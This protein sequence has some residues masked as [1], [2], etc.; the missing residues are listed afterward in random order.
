M[1]RRRRRPSRQ[2]VRVKKGN[3]FFFLLIGLAALVFFNRDKINEFLGEKKTSTENVTTEKKEKVE[4]NKEQ[5]GGETSTINT[6]PTKPSAPVNDAAKKKKEEKVEKP[7]GSSTNNTT[8]KKKPLV[9]F[10]SEFDKTIFAKY[11]NPFQINASG[12]DLEKVIPVAGSKAVKIQ[13]VDAKKGTYKVRVDKAGKAEVWLMAKVDG[14]QDLLQTV[15][16]Q[17]VPLSDKKRLEQSQQ[18]QKSAGGYM[19]N[20]ISDHPD[21]L[22]IGKPNLL[23]VAVA[24]SDP[25]QIVAS[26]EGGNSSL[27]PSKK[28]GFFEVKATKPGKAKVTVKLKEGGNT[29]L[30]GE[31]EYLVLAPPPPPKPKVA[32]NPATTPSIPSPSSAPI[33]IEKLYQGI[34]QIIQLPPNMKDATLKADNAKISPKGPGKFAI[35]PLRGKEVTLKV[36]QLKEGNE[37]ILATQKVNIVPIPDPQIFLNNAQEELETIK[38]E[39]LKKAVGLV[40]IQEDKSLPVKFQVVSF[41]LKYYPEDA[42]PAQANNKGGAFTKDAKQ[43]IDQAKTGDLFR[44]TKVKVRGTDNRVRDLKG[45]TLEIQ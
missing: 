13:A 4:K 5:K 43:L 3:I 2:R 25:T 31:K 21:T 44:F 24:E 33:Q 7:S 11:D 19:W 9:G 37:E 35:R 20:I 41:V 36:V 40:S 29:M 1:S 26:I 18:V 34:E 38:A 28:P 16:L 42:N 15:P 12:I 17:V 6:N 30:V 32:A 10:T 8:T 27:Q 14:K 22:F 45:P 39:D 23:E